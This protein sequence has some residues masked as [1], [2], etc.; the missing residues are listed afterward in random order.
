MTDVEATNAVAGTARS[1][2]RLAIICTHP[3]QYQVPLWR[4]LAADE[5][6]RVHVYFGAVMGAAGYVDREFG[7]PVRWD[8]PLTVGFAHTFMPGA[9]AVQEVGPWTPSGQGLTAAL[10]RDGCDA[11]LVNAYASVFWLRAL[12]FAWSR[13]IPVVMRHEATDAAVGRGRLKAGLRDALLRQLY[14]RIAVFACI[15]TEAARHLARLGVPPDRCVSSPYC[16]DS[17]QFEA[18]RTRWLP[19]RSAL[20]AELGCATDDIVLL[21]SGK[22]VPKKDPELIPAAL[23]A[24]DPALRRRFRVIVLGDGKLRTGLELAIRDVTGGRGHFAGFVNQSEM[25]RWYT[26][27]DCLVLPSQRGAGETWGLVVNEALQFGLPALV[28]NG[29]GCAPDLI[30]PGRTGEVF[31][32]GSVEALAA[33]LARM[34]RLLPLDRERLA[35]ECR[36]RI[37]DFTVGRAAEG[38]RD[39]I[40]RAVARVNRSI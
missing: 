8:L 16:V 25:G 30:V 2:I 40:G 12:R 14:R 11:M 29:V 36:A 20:R 3:I 33:A 7:V 15:G 38:L 19:S 22:L 32:A 6:W 10:R 39:A 9:D 23:A 34:A 31:A 4:A 13:G 28:S 27:A 18:Q 26:A 35:V 5:R 17:E 37:A 1:R 24:L 21:F